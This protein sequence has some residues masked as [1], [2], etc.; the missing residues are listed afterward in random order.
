MNAGRKSI[1]LRLTL[2]FAAA[3]TAVLL[4]LGLVVG[5]TVDRHFVEQDMAAMN[6]R[7]QIAAHLLAGARSPGDLA[8]LR[9]HLESEMAASHHGLGGMA[10]AVLSGEDGA[11]TIIRTPGVDFPANL[12]DRSRI[13]DAPR[14]WHRGEQPW[15][16]IAAP[17]PTGIDGWPPALVAL[18]IDISHHER[19]MA[20]FRRTLW[21]FVAIA[22]ML[23]GFLGWAAVRR[24]LMPLSALRREAAAV[25][26]SRLDRRLPAESV[27]AELAELAETLNDMLARLEDS[28]RRLSDFSGDI[29]HELRTPLSN[30][31]TQT[32]VALAR[33]RSADEYREVL[34]SNAEEYEH[35]AHM[36]G[37]MLF[38]AQAD[39]GLVVPN[40]E[41][42]DLAAQ[43]REL[44]DF[45]EALAEEK[46]V[47]LSLE[48][49]GEVPGDRLMLRRAIGNLLANAIRHTPTGG[50]ICVR[51]EVAG[52]GAVILSVEN[53]GE[54]I[55]PEHLPRL[56]D[57][58]YRADPSRRREGEGAGLGLAITRSIARAHGGEITVRSEPEGTR[59]ELRLAK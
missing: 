30:L 55:P 51:I 58:F 53:T 46:G 29:A 49:K 13:A 3:S 26:A 36:I 47:R 56:F 42:V 41:P 23:T 39:H 59:F 24:G 9:Q 32:Q 7:M 5:D 4:A 11:Q 19:F 8:A 18:A 20:S 1:T 14:V 34:A 38:L 21:L 12:L 17:L 10:V 27:P 2:L 35:L 43:V 22:A 31:M 50:G 37:D 52:N 16:G 57:R 44:F 48:G 40:R 25:T 45:Y 33:A 54:T 6:G 28:F 15:R